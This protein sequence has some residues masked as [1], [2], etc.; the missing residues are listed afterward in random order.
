MCQSRGCGDLRGNFLGVTEED[1]RRIVPARLGRSTL[2]ELLRMRRGERD[3]Y[4]VRMAATDSISA[5]AR[6]EYQMRL[7]E[8]GVAILGK[9]V[10]IKGAS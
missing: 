1:V 8:R 3:D 7:R 10:W 9:A 4:R 2:C 5:R 6:L